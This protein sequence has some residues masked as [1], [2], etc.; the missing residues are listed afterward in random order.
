MNRRQFLAAA[1]V[2]G[3]AT[4]AGCFGALDDDDGEPAP[5]NPELDVVDDINTA[6]GLTNTAALAL[7]RAAT[8][9]EDPGAIEFDEDEPRKRLDAAR[10]ALDDAESQDDGTHA[11]DIE[12]ARSYATVVEALLDMFVELIDGASELEASSD[13]FD[14][15]DVDELRTSIDAAREPVDRALDARTAGTEVREE[16]DDDRLVELDAELESI[17]DGLDEL[18]AFTGGFDSL[19]AGYVEL[20]D[21]VEEVVEAGEA[22]EN[23]Q[24]DRARDEFE[25]ATVAFESAATTFEDG[26]PEAPEDLSDEF[27][28]AIDRSGSLTQLS[29]A[30]ES[31]L[32]GRDSLDDGQAEFENENFDAAEREFET[33]ESAFADAEADLADDPRPEGEFD[34]EFEQARCRSE[35]LVTAAEEFSV[36][37]HAA[38]RGDFLEAEGRFEAGEQ[39]LDRVSEC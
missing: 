38:D 15:E 21:G 29:T 5:R 14:T 26:E 17:L 20:L 9:F 2:T 3:S 30:H 19:T 33:A 8:N 37:A 6:I 13:E 1:T 7:D 32:D 12:L 4:V 10:D 39:E 11:D 27:E 31:M 36:A 23:E 24:F 16:L 28:R 22:F 34:S 35:Y 18:G 25:R